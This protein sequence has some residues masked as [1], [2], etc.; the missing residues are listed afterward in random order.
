MSE[1]AYEGDGP[2]GLLVCPIPVKT[3]IAEIDCHSYQE[4]DYH[5][6]RIK[7]S[8]GLGNG[9]ATRLTLRSN[10]GTRSLSTYDRTNAF[11]QA[12]GF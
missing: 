7:V 1:G 11:Y 10:S 4:E 8:E 2:L 3:K 6:D 12:Q 9:K 5:R